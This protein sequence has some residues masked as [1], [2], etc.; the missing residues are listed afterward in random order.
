MFVGCTVQQ[1]NIFLVTV[2]RVWYVVVG[3]LLAYKYLLHFLI[4]N[5]SNLCYVMQC[6]V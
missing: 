4:R 1:N 5:G 2:L 3:L 6:S